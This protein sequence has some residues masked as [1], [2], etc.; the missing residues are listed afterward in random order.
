[1]Q[2]KVVRCTLPYVVVALSFRG[3]RLPGM[4]VLLEHRLQFTWRTVQLLSSLK[5]EGAVPAMA[6]I[7]VCPISLG[8]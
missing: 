5:M 1:V 6:R 7:V 3:P 4:P 8:G 2:L